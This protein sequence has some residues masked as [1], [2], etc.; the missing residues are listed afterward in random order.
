MPGLY[1][2]GETAC[3]SLNGANRLG[4]NSLTELLVFGRRAALAAADFARRR[5]R[6]APGT[7][8]TQQAESAVRDV[9]ETLLGQSGTE[10]LAS[11]RRDMMQALEDGA[12][13]YRDANGLQRADRVLRSLRARYRGITIHDR[14]NVFNTELLQMLELRNMLD[15][16][17]AVVAA[18][19]ARRES[20]GAHQRLDHPQRD[21]DH[22]LAHSLA[23]RIAGESPGIGWRP[24]TITRSPP[25]QRVYSGASAS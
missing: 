2:I 11:V 4:S 21:D 7:A 17:E 18:A 14:S 24:V 6:Q 23:T 9:R 20:R 12:G 10:W 13:I 8:A 19:L 3:G 16:A 5:P 1:A 22:F 15:V 25:G